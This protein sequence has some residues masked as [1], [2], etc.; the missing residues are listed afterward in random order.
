MGNRLA[1]MGVGKGIRRPFP[2][3]R[4]GGGEAWNT[5]DF[6][7]GPPKCGGCQ[8]G[9]AEFRRSVR[10]RGV[11]RPP[12]VWSVVSHSHPPQL[13]VGEKG[14]SAQKISGDL[15]EIRQNMDDT[16]SGWPNVGVP[17]VPV[18]CRGV[19]WGSDDPFVWSSDSH[20]PFP[21][22]RLG[23]KGVLES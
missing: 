21:I 2:R 6:G 15:E 23:K 4:V 20:P 5:S 1:H 11:P 10:F 8:R 22:G 7:R 12:F 3:M 16:S 19:L 9:V 13:G 18:E 17:S 14:R